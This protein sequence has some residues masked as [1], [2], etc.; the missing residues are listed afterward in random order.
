MAVYNTLGQ[1]VR[2]LTRERYSAGVH[3]VVWDGRDEQGA[4]LS[5]GIYFYRIQAGDQFRSM[6]KMLL[7]K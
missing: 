4:A 6:R 5:S 7:V 3:R 1:K 2:V